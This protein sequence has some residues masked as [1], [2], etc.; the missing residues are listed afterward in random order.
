MPQALQTT[1]TYTVK[2]IRLA[3]AL[4]QMR[5]QRESE[6]MLVEHVLPIAAARLP[7]GQSRSKDATKVASEAS[8]GAL[9]LCENKSAKLAGIA[10][11][12]HAFSS[13]PALLAPASALLPAGG[14][15]SAVCCGSLSFT[16]CCS[17]PWLWLTLVR[18]HRA[19]SSGWL[20]SGSPMQL[21]RYLYC[22]SL[23]LTVHHNHN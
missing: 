11:S 7:H 16:F 12:G 6:N 10:P 19:V 15:G 20:C 18:S 1:C 21:A 9:S 3:H 4:E 5:L 22:R 2:A 8:A 17:V 23:Q 13:V 14:G